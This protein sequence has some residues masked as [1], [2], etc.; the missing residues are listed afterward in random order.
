MFGVKMD[1]VDRRAFLNAR[2]SV[3]MASPIIL[4]NVVLKEAALPIGDGKMVLE[5]L[6]CAYSQ[7][8]VIDVTRTSAFLEQI[9]TRVNQFEYITIYHGVEF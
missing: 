3:E 4:N 5:P 9:R 8:D 2:N 6:G 1:K 7:Q